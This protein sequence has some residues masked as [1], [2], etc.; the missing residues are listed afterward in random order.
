MWGFELITRV[1]GGS[2]NSWTTG[3]AR[4]HTKVSRTAHLCD[5]LAEFIRI[6]CA[7]VKN[8]SCG[9]RPFSY[10]FMELGH[11]SV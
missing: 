3:V 4:C 1:V 6:P 8:P 2:S 11:F 5:F 10:F 9:I 7:Q